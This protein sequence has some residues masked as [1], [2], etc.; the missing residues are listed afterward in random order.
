MRWQKLRSDVLSVGA[1]AILVVAFFFRFFFPEPQL[2]VTPD[3]GRSD[4]WHFSVITK[5][6]LG[7]SLHQGELPLWTSTMGAGFPLIGE[8]Q[9]GAFY[10]PNLIFFRLFDPVG[11][12]NLALVLAVLTLGWG[13]YVWLRVMRY[14]SVPSL[15]AAITLSL[16]GM[17]MAQ[18]PHIALLQGFSLLPWIAA[19]TL[20]LSR[21]IRREIP[22][23][24]FAGNFATT[25]TIGLWA[26][27]VSQQLLA[28]F[29]QASFVTVLFVSCYY[30]WL[31]KDHP[32][33]RTSIGWYAIAAVLSLGLSAI[34]LF[35][36]WEFLS[37][38]NAAGGLDPQIASYFSYPLKHLITL[39]FPF[40]LGSPK[41]ASYP[42]FTKFDGSI[43]WENVG[44]IG[45]FPVALLLSLFLY[46]ERVRT[47][48]TRK[49]KSY[50]HLFFFLSVMLVSLLLMLGK[51][52]P[53][54]LIYSF[55]PFNL[56][57]VP[58]RFIWILIPAIL[59]LATE[60]WTKLWHTPKYA[61]FTRVAL[62]GLAAY[63]SVFLINAWYSYH[64]IEP[65]ILWLEA[66]VSIDTLKQRGGRVLTVG[67]E[68]AHNR[69]FL[70]KGWTTPGS[71]L[72]LKNALAP[73]SNALWG[74]P[75][76]Q[77]YAGRFLRRPGLLDELLAAH[78][79]ADE[80]N[81]TLSAT[82]KK[83]LDMLSVKTILAALPLTQTGLVEFASWT[84]GDQTI[85]AWQNPTSL[86]RAYLATQ[87]IVATTKEEAFAAI[88]RDNFT[89]GQSVIVEQSTPIEQPNSTHGRVTLLPQ[90]KETELVIRVEQNM[91]RMIL[92]ITDTYYPGWIAE[93]DGNNSPVFP[94]NIRQMGI[95][96]PAG[97]HEVRLTFTPISLFWGALV[98]GGTLALLIALTAF[99]L[100]SAH[101]RTHQEVPLPGPHRP[102]NH[103]TLR[104]RKEVT[105]GRA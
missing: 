99:P 87:P 25:K 27:L 104:L 26:I 84:S 32:D 8:G 13:M 73:D 69:I 92:V 31:M 53:L 42:A 68:A 16:S 76:A 2:L 103:G 98:S 4:S 80:Q 33:K 71:Y 15:F 72:P 36:S 81:A 50:S 56:F 39:L 83:L 21:S 55:F 67:A 102:R 100:V 82:G 37:Q 6:L 91:T 49:V 59:V 7:K 12:Y 29:P 41:D 18:L 1:L 74:V 19:A 5:F 44:G 38:S 94:V 52:S 79:T 48:F 58:S 14:S 62:V 65:A 101:S 10:L 75:S 51:Y 89:P 105:K 85:T 54:Y 77:V 20:L 60:A 30:V 40:A 28:G 63:N 86:P 64:A 96:V 78:L 23:S 34:Q 57:R 93:V 17:V 22:R 46:K 90:T 61:F 70:D 95:L 35:P 47:Y 11:A 45:L 9:I 24:R 43:F 97:D 88:A 3:F 66:P